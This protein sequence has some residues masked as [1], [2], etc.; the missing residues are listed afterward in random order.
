VVPI[1]AVA[2]VDV[3]EPVEVP[4]NEPAAEAPAVAPRSAAVHLADLRSTWAPSVVIV[5]DLADA[6][7]AQ[8][9]PART[10]YSRRLEVDPSLRASLQLSM[11]VEEGVVRDVRVVDGFQSSLAP[12]RERVKG[13]RAGTLID[14]GAR[15][16][17]YAALR[18]C[19]LDAMK[20]LSFTTPG[21]ATMWF[22]L[23][24]E[25]W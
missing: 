23:V 13:A 2:P 12:A 5:S 14:H 10:C 6:L 18:E 16:P 20:G 19:V 8:L 25:G 7:R 3:P 21:H 24:F 11:T 1:V 9:G 4:S 15:H 22:R 17:E